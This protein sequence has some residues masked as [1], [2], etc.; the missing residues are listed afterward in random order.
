MTV[1]EWHLF[2]EG[3]SPYDKWKL[4]ETRCLP[5]KGQQ[6]IPADVNVVVCGNLHVQTHKTF[7]DG[8][9]KPVKVNNSAKRKSVYNHDLMQ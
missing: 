9:I 5:P 2:H 6:R 1:N 8:S 3:Q 7:I 4:I